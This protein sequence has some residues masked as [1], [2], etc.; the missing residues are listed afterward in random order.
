MSEFYVFITCRMR[1][2]KQLKKSEIGAYFESH[3]PNLKMDIYKCPN[4]KISSNII[5]LKKHV[6]NYI[7]LSHHIR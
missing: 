7:F 1:Y 4:P 5:F 3:L 6:L 2:G